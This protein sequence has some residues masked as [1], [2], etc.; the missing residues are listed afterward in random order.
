M[1]WRENNNSTLSII[2]RLC[3]LPSIDNKPFIAVL[4]KDL[5]CE[6]GT[7]LKDSVVSIKFDDCMYYNNN[8]CIICELKLKEYTQMPD[9]HDDESELDCNSDSYTFSVPDTNQL[10]NIMDDLFEIQSEKTKQYE[11]YRNLYTDYKEIQDMES[12]ISIPNITAT[13]SVLGSISASMA[14]IHTMIT[15]GSLTTSEK[16]SMGMAT[17]GFLIIAVLSCIVAVRTKRKRKA[18]MQNTKAKMTKLHK[19]IFE[20]N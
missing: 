14:F 9:L 8:E 4:K 16:A 10:Q 12:E 13:I 3:A 2:E 17:G 5:K 7:F 6:K 11:D 19:Q 15:A 1:P 20:Y 18:R